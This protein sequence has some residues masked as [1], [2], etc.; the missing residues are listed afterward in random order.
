MHIEMRILNFLVE[1]VY[2]YYMIHKVCLKMKEYG[3]CISR[4]YYF[5][6]CSNIK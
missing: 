3:I 4:I 2:E 6:L 5:Y 1:L